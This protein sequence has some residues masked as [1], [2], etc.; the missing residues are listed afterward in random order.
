MSDKI[1]QEI[2][3]C[4]KS[5]LRV[6][7]ASD[8]AQPT[9]DGYAARYDMPSLTLVDPSRGEYTE[10]INRGALTWN[11]VIATW[12]HDHK[13]IPLATYQAGREQNSLLLESDAFGLRYT[14]QAPKTAAGDTL[15]EA[16]RRGD[17]TE[18]SFAFRVALDDMEW[19][20]SSDGY[21]CNITAAEV[22]DVSPVLEAQYPSTSVVLRS[23]EKKDEEE[24]LRVQAEAAKAEAIERNKQAEIEHAKAINDVWSNIE[25]ELDRD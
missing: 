14:F 7:E 25:D 22:F 12:N 23:M 11:K 9:I 8:G 17:I 10:T 4:S 16:I 6:H 3:F 18:S 15:V 13:A 21:T 5:E 19:H 20:K 2:R 1:T 24:A